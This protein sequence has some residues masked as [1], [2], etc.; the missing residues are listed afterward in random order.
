MDKQV[1]GPRDASVRE[2]TRVGVILLSE[3][4]L[5]LE[6]VECVITWSPNLQEGGWLPRGYWKCPNGCNV[7]GES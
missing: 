2:L 5:T 7:G 1:V 3:Q 4:N 6:C